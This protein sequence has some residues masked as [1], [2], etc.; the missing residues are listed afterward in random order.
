M[1]HTVCMSSTKAAQAEATRRALL[2]IGR[3]LFERRGFQETSQDDLVAAAGLTRGALYRVVGGRGGF[4]GGGR[5]GVRGG[6]RQRIRERA[7]RARDPL[8]AVE[9]GVGAFLDC[10]SEPRLQRLLLV[11]GPAVLGWH[12]WR[13]LD[14]Q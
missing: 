8:G 4:L 2:R 13:A 11:D 5:G 1:I 10:C 9:A 3:K 14:L 7:R 12:E 6:G